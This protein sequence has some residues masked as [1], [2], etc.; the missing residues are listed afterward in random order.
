MT[1]VRVATYSETLTRGP[2]HCIQS[3][4]HYRIGRQVCAMQKL[5]GYGAV[6]DETS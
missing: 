1:D 3:K 5:S 2:L 6:A 4:G